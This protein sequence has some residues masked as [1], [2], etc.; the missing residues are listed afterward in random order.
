MDLSVLYNRNKEDRAAVVNSFSSLQKSIM[1]GL[2]ETLEE[3]LLS[4][5]LLNTTENHELLRRTIL[6]HIGTYPSFDSNL[7]NVDVSPSGV[8]GTLNVDIQFA[9]GSVI[10]DI[11][12]DT[13]LRGARSEAIEWN[14]PISTPRP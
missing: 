6:T 5:P 1:A 7:V 11:R 14:Y 4:R 12:N 8:A 13:S 9:N 2:Q 10:R 3:T